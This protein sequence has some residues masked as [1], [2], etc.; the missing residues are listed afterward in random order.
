MSKSVE[1]RLRIQRTPTTQEHWERYADE[2]LRRAERA[3]RERDEA[4]TR[5]TF[6]HCIDSLE[7]DELAELAKFFAARAA[8]GGDE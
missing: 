4:R 5:L 3:E 8:G 7:T 1:R 6:I 2:L